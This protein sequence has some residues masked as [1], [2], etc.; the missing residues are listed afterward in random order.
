MKTPQV[1]PT[2]KKFLL[3]SIAT[4]CTATVLKFITKSDKKESKNAQSDTVKM[5]TQD[6]TLVEIDR[7]LLTAS[8]QKISNTELKQWIQKKS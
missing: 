2:R 8:A 4:L 3:W 7:K 6:G 5:L 1:P